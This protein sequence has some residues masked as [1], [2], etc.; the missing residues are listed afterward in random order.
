MCR[1]M[2]WIIPK[3]CSW[4]RKLEIL[5]RFLSQ[6]QG[7]KNTPLLN[8]H[9]DSHRNED[10]CGF[11]FFDAE[12]WKI[13]KSDS[14]FFP[15]DSL[16]SPKIIVGHLRHQGDGKG[17]PSSQNSHPFVYQQYMFCHNGKIFDF[18]IWETLLC[19]YIDPC[20]LSERTSETDSEVIFFLLIT[21]LQDAPTFLDALRKFNQLLFYHGI[22]YIGNFIFSDSSYIHVT[23]LSNSA[24]KEPCSLY[25]HQE[26]RLIS[27]EPLCENMELFPRNGILEISLEDFSFKTITN[28]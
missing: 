11:A 27:S 24:E 5:E 4:E 13:I 28:L 17:R 6:A 16:A 12:V 2:L 20:V 3:T 19:F 10:G 7:H 21:F 22:D 25:I 15:L 26:E 14:I 1:I 23:R 9:Y 8:Y 18:P